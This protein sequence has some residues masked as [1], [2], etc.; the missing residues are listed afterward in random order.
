MMTS[1]Q[2]LF[3]GIGILLFPVI[4]ILVIAGGILLYDWFKKKEMFTDQKRI[5][6]VIGI[7]TFTLLPLRFIL[8]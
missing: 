6:A 4:C 2:A 3:H 7:V 8:L 1:Q 5:L